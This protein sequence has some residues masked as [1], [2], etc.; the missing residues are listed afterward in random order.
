MAY[1]F[2]DCTISKILILQTK[3]KQKKRPASEESDEEETIWEVCFLSNVIK[4]FPA[5]KRL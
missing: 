3:K 2:G 4:E 1:T 5:T